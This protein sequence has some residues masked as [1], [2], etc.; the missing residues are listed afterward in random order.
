[1]ADGMTRAGCVCFVSEF[2]PVPDAC[3]CGR[4][5]M[6]CIWVAGPVAGP[7]TSSNGLITLSFTSDASITQSGFYAVFTSVAT[8]PPC[9]ATHT[10]GSGSA[11]FTAAQSCYYTMQATG[12]HRVQVRGS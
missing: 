12:G 5:V 2:V 3:V 8:V 1:M 7:Y 4:G 11:F 10:V 6:V 9:S